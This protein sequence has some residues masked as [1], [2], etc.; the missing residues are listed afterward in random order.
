MEEKEQKTKYCEGETR[1]RESIKKGLK[2]WKL[3]S[4]PVQFLLSN[5]NL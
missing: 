2:L 1:M 4:F 3:L 5:L